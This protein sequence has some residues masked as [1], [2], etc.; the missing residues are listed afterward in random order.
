MESIRR[1]LPGSSLPGQDTKNPKTSSGSV[2]KEMV[3]RPPQIHD[4][5][6]DWEDY[7]K[8][9]KKTGYAALPNCPKCKGKGWQHP[10]IDGEVSYVA[11]LLSCDY[12]GCLEDSFKRYK[13]GESYLKSIGVMSSEQTFGTFRQELGTRDAYAAFYWLAWPE[14]S[15]N[16]TRVPFLLCYGG[17][18]NGKTH[19]CNALAIELNN[20][21][22]GV[23]LYAVADMIS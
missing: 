13:A 17:T 20:Q 19:L 7:Y 8:K 22:I 2:L 21:K 15:E 12:A 18:G 1:F 3:Y 9:L 10:R 11:K 5:P 4:G 14:Q 16:K 6:Q 23:R